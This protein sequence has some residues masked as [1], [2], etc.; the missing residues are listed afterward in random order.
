MARHLEQLGLSGLG[1][2]KPLL[3]LYILERLA[4]YASELDTSRD[5][6]RYFA[7]L[8]NLLMFKEAYT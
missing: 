3:L 8:A 2:T 7:H 4:Y 5:A 6:L 1:I